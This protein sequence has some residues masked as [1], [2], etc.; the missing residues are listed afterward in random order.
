MGGDPLACAPSEPLVR[1]GHATAGGVSPTSLCGFSAHPLPQSLA[2][3]LLSLGPI[4]PSRARCRCS[5]QSRWGAGGCG[6]CFACSQIGGSTQICTSAVASEFLAGRS[7]CWLW[8]GLLK[9]WFN[10][11][12]VS[13][14]LAGRLL[15]HL[16]EV[17]EPGA[18][19]SLIILISEG[20]PTL[21]HVAAAQWPPALQP[22]PLCS[23]CRD[24]IPQAH[25][26]RQSRA[27]P[28][29]AEG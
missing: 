21:F 4:S 22:C 26:Q 8:P 25:V 7:H 15:F 29:G 6:S 2:E 24:V 16:V 17:G 3:G 11:T 14:L 1:W 27:F 18:H 12:C 9:L 5:M 19:L 28:V 23:C 10:S 20:A 13:V